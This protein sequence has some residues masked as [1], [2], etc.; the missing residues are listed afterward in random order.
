MNFTV[1]G[2]TA[3]SLILRPDK[4]I[5][6]YFGKEY[7]VEYRVEELTLVIPKYVGR[8]DILIRSAGATQSILLFYLFL[9]QSTAEQFLNGFGGAPF[10]PSR[11]LPLVQHLSS[12]HPP[13]PHRLHVH[14]LPRQQLLGQRHGRS[15][16][17]AGHGLTSVR[18]PGFPPQDGLLQVHRLVDSRRPQHTSTKEEDKTSCPRT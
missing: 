13:R 7:L 2:Q 11:D 12:V 5:V 17:H 8:F 1:Q 10:S 9:I 6:K 4:D 15:H 16:C 14:V 3:R 18:R